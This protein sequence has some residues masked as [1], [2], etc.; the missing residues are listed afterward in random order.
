[1]NEEIIYNGYTAK[2]SDYECANGNL[3]ISLN[4]I[5]NDA[6]GALHPILNSEEI[7][8]FDENY[9]LLYIHN[10]TTESNYILYKKSNYCLCFLKKGNTKIIEFCPVTSLLHVQKINSIGNILIISFQETTNCYF[11]WSN[12]SYINL[13]RTVPKI[14]LSFGL[15]GDFCSN[16]NHHVWTGSGFLDPDNNAFTLKDTSIYT[17]LYFYASDPNHYKLSENDSNL[18]TEKVMSEINKFIAEE[19]LSKGKFC[20]P[21]FVRYAI[22]LYDGSLIH[23]SCPILMTPSTLCSIQAYA[24]LACNASEDTTKKLRTRLYMMAA[25]LDYNFVSTPSLIDEWKDLIKS[26]DIFI[27]KPI[28]THKQDGKIEAISY[29]K[30]SEHINRSRFI[31]KLATPSLYPNATFEADIKKYGV[32]QF[33]DL[34]RAY[35][36]KYTH[37]SYRVEDTDQIMYHNVNFDLVYE[38]PYKEI[39]E[40]YKEI[41]SC[42]TFYKIHSITIDEIIEQSKDTNTRHL[43]NIPPRYL[44]SL[45]TREVMNDDYLSHDQIRSSFSYS[46]NNRLNLCGLSRKPYSGHSPKTMFSHCTMRTSSTISSTNNKANLTINDDYE[47]EVFNYKI[48]TYINENNQ[49]FYVETEIDENLASY[50]V[51]D[52]FDNSFYKQS[53]WGAYLFY[54]NTNAYKMVIYRNNEPC[55]ATKLTAHDFLNGAFAFVGFNHFFTDKDSANLSSNIGK[56]NFIKITNKIYTSEINNPF[57]F[58]LNGINTIN[59]DEIYSICSATKALSEGQFGQFPLYCFTSNGIWA[60]EVSDTGLYSTKQPISQH[61]AFPNSITQLKNNVCFADDKGIYLLDGSN[62]LCVSNII[63]NTY[64]TNTDMPNIDKIINIFNKT[65]KSQK[66]ILT[67]QDITLLPLSDFLKNC[68]I[69]YSHKLNRL[70]IYNPD[71]NY[72]YVYSFISKT[73]G[74]MYSNLRSN[75]N[76]YTETLATTKDNKLINLSNEVGNN[77]TCLIITRPFKLGNDPNSFKT[78]NTIIQRG[79]FP[80]DSVKQVLYGSNDLNNWHIVWSSQDKYMR[81]F[82]GSPYKFY[83]MA[84]ICNLN[85]NE[86]IHGCSISYNPRITNQLR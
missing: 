9:E 84:L 55:F 46:Y 10:M 30:L 7:Y 69:I 58:P 72:S 41:N 56:G 35:T 33:E 34:Y 63:E 20:F 75:V 19:T 15:V 67:T 80:K 18:V 5:A 85:K 2:P 29:K 60:M 23:H 6:E 54:P 39:D 17:D 36:G 40:I 52:D 4:A 22:R 38:L 48:R 86:S 82:R 44:N 13:G 83:R 66:N 73:W 47:G 12:S 51:K 81:G 59:A 26:I 43:I 74:M 53:T 78:I 49:N 45:V 62:V 32:Y 3:A 1:M 61:I 31:G 50:G 24:A 37:D 42:S 77:T 14:N 8:D 27:S 57:F 21:F 25:Q 16:T 28:Y 11:L 64:L 68:R 70:I 65:K 71:V 76:S 79:N